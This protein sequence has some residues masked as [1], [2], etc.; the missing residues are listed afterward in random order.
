MICFILPM[1]FGAALQMAAIELMD[2][3]GGDGTI[4]S[5]ASAVAISF[6]V[7]RRSVLRG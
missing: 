5:P 1:H 2:A 6:H 4:F 3:L 7:L